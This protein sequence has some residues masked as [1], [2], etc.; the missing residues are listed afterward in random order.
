MIS[1][2]GKVHLRM[3]LRVGTIW[4]KVRLSRRCLYFI[5]TDRRTGMASSPKGMAPSVCMRVIL[6]Q[7]LKE[8]FCNCMFNRFQKIILSNDINDCFDRTVSTTSLL[9]DAR[10][11]LGTCFRT[12]APGMLGSYHTLSTYAA[13]KIRIFVVQTSLV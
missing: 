3:T 12:P 5:H 13:L 1:A 10:P 9:E 2:R 8:F 11:I 7:P 4:L 6:Q